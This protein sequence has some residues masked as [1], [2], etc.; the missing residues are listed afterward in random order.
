MM[1]YN[2]EEKGVPLS[3]EQDEWLH[4]T[5]DEPDEQ[6]LKAHYIQHSKQPESINDTYMVETVDSNVIPNSSDMCDNEGKA[7]QNAED[8]EDEPLT[9]ELNECKYALEESNDIRDRC[10]SALHDQEI[11]LERWQQPIT[12]EITM[13]VK[14]LLIPLLIKTKANANEFERALKQEMFEDLQYVQSLEKEVDEVESEKAE[15]SKEYDLLLQECVS[16]DIMCAILSSFDNIDEYS[17]MACDYL[18]AVAK[19]K[20]LENELSK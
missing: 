3:A 9:H 2:Q 16:K 18:E 11:E 10:R 19:C 14:N 6:E 8:Y 17:K 20:R 5:D 13:L 4:D 12:H 1:L 15:F 7:D